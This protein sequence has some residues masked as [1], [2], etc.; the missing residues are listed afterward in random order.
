MLCTIFLNEDSKWTAPEW[1][2]RNLAAHLE[3]SF[4]FAETE[5]EQRFADLLA[6]EARVVDL[7]RASTAEMRDLLES[8]EIARKWV[9]RP[10][11]WAEPAAAL[12]FITAYDWFLTLLRRDIR[13]EEAKPEIK[14]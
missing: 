6:G 7:T 8:A 5:I 10:S 1:L 13:V 11:E 4:R 14:G 12:E 2:A 9:K 3:S